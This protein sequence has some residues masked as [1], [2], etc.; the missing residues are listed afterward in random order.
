MAERF[1]QVSLP[2]RDIYWEDIGERLTITGVVMEGEGVPVVI[3][4]PHSSSKRVDIL[5]SKF[6]QM[7][8]EEWSKLI[9]SSD[10]PKI[11][12]LDETG[13]I[14]AIHRKVRYEVSGAIQQKVW[15]RDGLKCMYCYGK[16]GDVQLTIDHFI[17]LEMGGPNVPSNYLSACRRCNKLK[18]GRHPQQFTPVD[19]DRLV[20]YLEKKG[21]RL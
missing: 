11:F 10:D 2:S 13:G 9:Q 15:V 6:L 3:M 20:E 7:S 8:S 1:Y 14:K 21:N 5:N 17:P 16:M 18:G 12:E 19:Y 4:T